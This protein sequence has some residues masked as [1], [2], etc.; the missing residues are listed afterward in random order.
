MMP[1]LEAALIYLSNSSQKY[2]LIRGKSN[3]NINPALQETA[4]CN[5]S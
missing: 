3:K 5:V 4:G 1:L 2:G